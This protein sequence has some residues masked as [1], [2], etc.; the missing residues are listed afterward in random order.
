MDLQKLR[1]SSYSGFYNLGPAQESHPENWNYGIALKYKFNVFDEY[2]AVCGGCERS[3][4]ACGYNTQTSSFVCNCPVGS[5]RRQIAFSFIT[6]VPL[7]FLGFQ[8]APLAILF[9]IFS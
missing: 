2:P 1:C 7:F 8:V 9:H 4:G 5:I 3:N 6:R